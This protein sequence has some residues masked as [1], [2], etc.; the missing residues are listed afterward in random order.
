M[1]TEKEIFASYKALDQRMLS[2]RAP[3]EGNAMKEGNEMAIISV[4][5]HDL[6]AALSLLRVYMGLEEPSGH[7]KDRDGK[8]VDASYHARISRLEKALEAEE[9]T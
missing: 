3:T 6:K 9:Q 7:F 2:A 4:D 5:S 1:P 8:L